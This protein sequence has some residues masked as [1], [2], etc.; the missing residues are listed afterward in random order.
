MSST[1]KPNTSPWRRPQP[2]ASLPPAWKRLGRPAMTART[3]SNDQGMTW[4]RPRDVPAARS[5]HV[6]VPVS[7][8]GANPQVSGAK[9]G[10]GPQEAAIA[11]GDRNGDRDHGPRQSLGTDNPVVGTTQQEGPVPSTHGDRITGPAP[12]LLGDRQ[13]WR[14]S[15]CGTGAPWLIPAGPFGCPRCWAVGGSARAGGRPRFLPAMLPHRG[16]RATACRSSGVLGFQ[17]MAQLA[18]PRRHWP[19][20]HP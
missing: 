4:D 8:S 19:E 13:T 11:P 3:R 12:G 9:M 18:M 1:A 2:K 17:A 6:P 14:C 10:T 20:P 16:Q 5:P 15:C 7:T